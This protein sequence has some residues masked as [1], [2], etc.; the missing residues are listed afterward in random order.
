ME[1]TALVLQQCNL[2][3]CF[4]NRQL[5]DEERKLDRSKQFLYKKEFCHVVDNFQTYLQ[6][7]YCSILVAYP[8]LNGNAQMDAERVFQHTDMNALRLSFARSS[9]RD[10]NQKSL[11]KQSEDV[12]RRWKFAL[13]T[14]P[15][16][17][18]EIARIVD[19]RNALTHSRGEIE[20]GS[21]KT[22]IVFHGTEIT[23]AMKL[24]SDTVF[25]IDK[26]AVQKW[27]RLGTVQHSNGS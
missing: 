17:A 5:S 27:Q 20:C 8:L 25:D 2:A 9:A 1:Y 10:L 15:A 16:V 11:L 13:F 7:L 21:T 23:N 14:S 4:H 12:R 24:L 22:Q 19:I 3:Q 18:K 6:E 26:R